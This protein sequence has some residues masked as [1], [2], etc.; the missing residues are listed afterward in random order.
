LIEPLCKDS[1]CL[2]V[3]SAPNFRQPSIIPDVTIG[4]NG[5]AS[6][7]ESDILCTTSHLF[8]RACSDRERKTRDGLSSRYFHSVWLDAKCPPGA[9]ALNSMASDGICHSRAHVVMPED[10]S[11]LVTRA[12]GKSLWVSTGV[13]AICLAVV[14]DALVVTVTG[15]SL[16]HGHFDENEDAPR[17]HTSEDREC[18]NLLMGT[19][20]DS[21]HLE[22]SLR[23]R[24]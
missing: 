21:I 19:H 17:F 11:E 5:G 8:R 15:I 9:G 6:L 4:A 20:G 10:R 2:V 24:L 14:S 22:E 16:G 23:G 12:C 7:V 3:G 18:L 13:W 1:V